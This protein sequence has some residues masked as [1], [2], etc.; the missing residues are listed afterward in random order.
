MWRD[1]RFAIARTIVAIT[2]LSRVRPRKL[3]MLASL[4]LGEAFCLP[5]RSA[6]RVSPDRGGHNVQIACPNRFSARDDYGLRSFADRGRNNRSRP[7]M[8]RHGAQ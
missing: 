6:H 7:A 8:A 2:D 1:A 3:P 5:H 4:S